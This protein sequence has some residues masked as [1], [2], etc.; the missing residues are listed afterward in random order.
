M[1]AAAPLSMSPMFRDDRQGASI[2]QTGSGPQGGAARV[3]PLLGR[4]VASRFLE[5]AFPPD[6]VIDR[7]SASPLS[8]ETRP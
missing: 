8:R 4:S 3:D 2:G 5:P 6:R 7:S 1:V